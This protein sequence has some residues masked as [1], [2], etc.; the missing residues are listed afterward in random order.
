MGVAEEMDLAL[1]VKEFGLKLFDKLFH[2]KNLV[3]LEKNF[4][5]ASNLQKNLLNGK[6]FKRH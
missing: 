4:T 2:D 1:Y 6:S 3:A 5:S